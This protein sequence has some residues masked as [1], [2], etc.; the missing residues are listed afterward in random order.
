MDREITGAADWFDRHESSDR[1]M[2]NER[3][4]RK[5]GGGFLHGRVERTGEGASVTAVRQFTTNCVEFLRVWRTST[6][7][8]PTTTKHDAAFLAVFND[9]LRQAADMP[10]RVN[11]LITRWPASVIGKQTK[12][13]VLFTA[14]C[15]FGQVQKTVQCRPIAVTTNGAPQAS[16]ITNGSY[17]SRSV[18]FRELRWQLHSTKFRSLKFETKQ[19]GRNLPLVSSSIRRYEAFSEFRC[20][21]HSARS[22][23]VMHENCCHYG[24][25]YGP[26]L[27]LL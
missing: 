19:T 25:H 9:S 16:Q 2:E 4:R 17:D 14:P 5:G 21:K 22:R 23:N 15:P 10:I 11:R 26:P 24:R 6:K 20:S 3:V 1:K 7:R 27:P 18:Q 12:R 13:R 8:L